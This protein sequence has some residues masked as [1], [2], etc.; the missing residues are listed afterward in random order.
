M[1]E[2]TLDGKS[3]TLAE[4]EAIAHGHA[5]IRL[6]PAAMERVAENRLAV[7]SALESGIPIYGATAGVGGVTAST[8]PG[9]RVEH[10]L[11]RGTAA[12]TGEPL[13]ADVVRA[14]MAIRLNGMLRGHSG[15]RPRLLEAIAAILNARLAPFVPSR[16]SAGASGDLAP[17]A[18]AFLPLIGEGF[19]LDGDGPPQAAG[20]VLQR[21]GLEPLE[22]A[23]KE[24]ISILN[25][26]HFM[27]GIG[28]LV[29]GR[30]ARLLDTADAVAAMT[31]DGL[32]GASAAFDPRI[33]ALRP[34]PGQA[35]SATVVRA[36]LTGSQ[37]VDTRVGH[38]H[39]AYSLRC[40][41]QVHGSAR[42]AH[43]FFAATIA[44]ELN[45]VTDNPIVFDS[46]LEVISAGNFHGQPLALA[47]D[48]LRIALADLAAF[49]ERR[50]FRLLS[51]SLGGGLRPFLIGEDGRGLGYMVP[52]FTCVSLVAEMR[53][54]A[55]PVSLDTA[56]TLDNLE[57][58][59]SFG[60]TAGLLTLETCSLLETVLAIEAMSAAQAL[61]EGDAPGEGVHALYQLVRDYL[62][63]LSADRPP[64]N[65]M[66]ATRRVIADGEMSRIVDR[67]G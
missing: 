28:S 66:E 38:T 30:V 64:A 9:A 37:R 39:D 20:E 41:P 45:A 8:G 56:P 4:A 17:S 55:Q 36:L 54:L 24:A 48:T 25:G 57:D 40:V 10:D 32:R 21:E 18:H 33:H 11:M 27:A 19:F 12:G 1:K 35:R 13:A 62:P 50:T 63:P 65:D 67:F 6:A 29:V 51:P 52:Q 31:I 60:M 14:A 43:A 22:L 47:F 15:V 16:G 61:V 59:V 23:P 49:S 34:L 42:H 53:V 7:D 46:P 5:T 3:L 2:L 26:T 44:D 58:H